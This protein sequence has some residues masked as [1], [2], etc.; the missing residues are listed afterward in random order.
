MAPRMLSGVLVARASG[1]S[2]REGCAEGGDDGCS[3][4]LGYAASFAAETGVG[5]FLR[6]NSMTLR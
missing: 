2:R 1:E 6:R 4:R 5:Y 3:A